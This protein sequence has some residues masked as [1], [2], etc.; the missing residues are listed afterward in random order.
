[1]VGGTRDT[2]TDKREW[3]AHIKHLER[4]IDYA[5]LL[6]LP[7]SDGTDAALRHALSY[8]TDARVYRV[9]LPE[10]AAGRRPPRSVIPARFTRQL[11][12]EGHFEP[13]AAESIKAAIFVFSV[14]EDA[15]GRCRIIQHPERVNALVPAAPQVTFRSIKERCQLVHAGPAAGQVDFRAF[16]TQFPLSVAVRNVFC[17]ELAS[18]DDE[19]RP[20]RQL[21]RLC[22]A[23]TGL[24]HMP[25]V[26]CTTTARLKDFPRRSAADDDHIDNVLYVGNPEDVAHDLADLAARC[27][28]AGVTIN[29]DV[30]DP[31]ALVS[32]AVDWCGLHLDFSAKSVCLT[33]KVVDKIRLSWANFARWS[34]RG[35]AA[36]IGLLF[37]SMQLLE[38]PTFMFFNLLRFVSHVG[39]EMQGRDDKCWDL[40]AEIWPSAA[41]DLAAWTQ[42]ALT[43]KPR[44][45]PK[46]EAPRVLALVDSSAYGWGYIA[47]DLA[48]GRVFMHGDR[49]ADDFVLQHGRD[50]LRR[51]VFT[52]P[53]GVRLMKQ[54]LLPQLD[55]IGCTV[56]VGSDNVTTVATYRR[57]FSAASYDLNAVAAADRL[58]GFDTYQ[59][60][61]VSVAGV[62][63]IYADALSRGTDDLARKDVGALVES[64]RR[65]LGV[66]PV[67]STGGGQA[68]AADVTQ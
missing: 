30:S 11:L 8:M 34:W 48:T 25:Y 4:R 2:P 24:A 40:A 26:A 42:L 51:S 64:L 31:R 33:Q 68:G 63:N 47:V 12:V 19:G 49:W 16:Y 62:D 9:H 55:G 10:W 17:A 14:F 6:A 41:A 57:G 58:S 32:T 39:R 28:I 29:E 65:L 36:H 5:A 56:R 38:I 21:Y 45:V 46:Q 61:Y 66:D 13:V 50:K 1:M 20:L 67:D 15:K 35:F 3:P 44:H 37:Y 53:H 52:E 54:H 18:T 23:P 59:F 60:E 43:N 22:V 7:A 27:N